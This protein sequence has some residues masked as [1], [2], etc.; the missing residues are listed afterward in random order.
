MHDE[1]GQYTIQLQLTFHHTL[2]THALC[3]VLLL[4]WLEMS[5]YVALTH[6]RDQR[7]IR[8]QCGLHTHHLFIAF[9]CMYV[10]VV[11]YTCTYIH[12]CVPASVFV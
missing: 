5:S 3:A 7:P 11:N 12:V 1:H 8:L 2:H 4:F 6:V 10:Q 9:T